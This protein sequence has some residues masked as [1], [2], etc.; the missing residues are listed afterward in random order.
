M[1]CNK[2]KTF[3]KKTDFLSLDH[4]KRDLIIGWEFCETQ[5]I[6]HL[7]KTAKCLKHFVFRECVCACVGVWE[8]VKVRES[9][10]ECVCVSVSVCV[11]AFL[12]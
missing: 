11:Q 12:L 3:G 8:R 2:A 5:L 7:L 6:I 1:Y 4:F 9:E 10:R